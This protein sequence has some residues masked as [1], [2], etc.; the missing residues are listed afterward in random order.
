MTAVTSSN[1]Y[2]NSHYIYHRASWRRGAVTANSGHRMSGYIRAADPTTSFGAAQ[3][4]R[5]SAA[6]Q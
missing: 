1:G 3:A 5:E 2:H 6:C 4:P